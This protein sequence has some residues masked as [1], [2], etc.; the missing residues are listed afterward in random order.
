MGKFDNASEIIKL[1]RE[2]ADLRLALCVV[3]KFENKSDVIQK[4][5][6]ALLKKELKVKELRK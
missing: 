1:Q 6:R 4:L 2:C 3:K 5:E